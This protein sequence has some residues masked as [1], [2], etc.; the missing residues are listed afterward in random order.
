MMALRSRLTVLR[1]ATLTLL[2]LSLVACVSP[3]GATEWTGGQTASYT[4]RVPHGPSYRVT[5]PVP[6]GL[7]VETNREGLAVTTDAGCFTWTPQRASLRGRTFERALRY[8]EGRRTATGRGTGRV[9]WA[10][11]S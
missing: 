4:V 11:S 6:S 7:T 9:R 10:L 1:L 2:G 3:A 8:Q 5:L